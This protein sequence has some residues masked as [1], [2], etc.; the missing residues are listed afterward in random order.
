[1]SEGQEKIEKECPRCGGK[2]RHSTTMNIKPKPEHRVYFV[3]CPD[4]A[5]RWCRYIEF[6]E[7]GENLG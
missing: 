3:Y 2:L 6:K 1:M 7:A 5:C 4:Y